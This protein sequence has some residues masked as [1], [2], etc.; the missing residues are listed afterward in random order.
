MGKRSRAGRRRNS[1][2]LAT[3]AWRIWRA[4]FC[5]PLAR[6]AALPLPELRA[7][8]TQ[9]LLA[10]VASNDALRQEALDALDTQVRGE[11]ELEFHAIKVS[12]SHACNDTRLADALPKLARARAGRCCKRS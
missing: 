3:K 6:P 12:Y 1:A 4:R 11:I 8:L 10:D 9:L 2:K 7:P 5:E